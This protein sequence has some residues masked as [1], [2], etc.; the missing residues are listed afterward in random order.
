MNQL[1]SNFTPSELSDFF[2]SQISSF[3]PQREEIQRTIPTNDTKFF[4]LLTKHGE[5]V[6]KDKNELLVFSCRYNGALSERSSRR[7]QFEVAKKVLKEDFKDG[8]IFVFYDE[9]GKFRF[10][11]IR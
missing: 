11:F 5:T 2:R 10:S 3:T 1:I 4:S 6:L 8:A 7:K 9:K